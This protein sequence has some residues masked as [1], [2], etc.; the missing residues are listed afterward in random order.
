MNGRVTVVVGGTSGI[1]LAT[2]RQLGGH[3]DTVILVARAGAALAAARAVVEAAGGTHVH[4]IP[5]DVNDRDELQAMVE[6]VVAVHGRI[7]ALVHTATVMAYGTIQQ[8]PAKVF[9]T[10]VD[11]A[12]HGTANLARAVLP[13][14]RRQGRGTFVIV[15]SLLGSIT[16]PAM[17]AYATSKWGQ[18][19]VART[20]QQELR[21]A[22]H[23]NVCMVSPGSINT[24]IY[25]QAANYTGRDARPPVPVLQP[26]VVAAVI[27]RLLD[28]PRKHVS[29]PVGPMN[30]IIIIGYR[31]MPWIFDRIVTPLFRLA[32]LTTQRDPGT[33]SVLEPD[34][35]KEREYG[36]WPD[37]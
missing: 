32:A 1:G 12:I 3:G 15:N 34:A 24:P 19:A 6:E 4:T 2:A 10:V 5:A 33:G 22:R 16:V 20:L 35:S 23:V 31:L 7:D 29:V 11:T 18:R 21:D 27:A 28:H 26:E 17:G 14:M 8:M 36:R 30:P 37:R 25:Y 13:V 9:D